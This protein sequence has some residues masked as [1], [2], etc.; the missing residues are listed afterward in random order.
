M[1]FQVWGICNFLC[2][3]DLLNPP[4]VTI[5]R[6][7]YP[8]YKRNLCKPNGRTL[9]VLWGKN[10]ATRLGSTTK[11]KAAQRLFMLVNVAVSMSRVHAPADEVHKH[12]HEILL[13]VRKISRPSEMSQY[14]LR[15]ITLKE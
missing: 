13:E 15:F 3:Q 9:I 8:W 12:N 1:I 6:C 10:T 11:T 7:L 5:H 2:W 14:G 4:L